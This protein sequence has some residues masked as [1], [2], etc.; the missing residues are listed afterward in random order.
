MMCR[1]WGPRVGVGV[2]EQAAVLWSLRLVSPIRGLK[3]SLQSMA[4]SVVSLILLNLGHLTLPA[5]EISESR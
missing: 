3:V 1:V 4:C 5:P 2:L